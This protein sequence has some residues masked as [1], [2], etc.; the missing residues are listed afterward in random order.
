MV[1]TSTRQYHATVVS[2]VAARTRK[3]GTIFP[4]TLQESAYPESYPQLSIETT[5]FYG[6]C[7]GMPVATSVAIPKIWHVPVGLSSTTGE[8][9][10]IHRC[11]VTALVRKDCVANL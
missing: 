6:F 3:E 7:F 8:I 9:S 10:W 4:E 1:L 2:A 11:G 5:V